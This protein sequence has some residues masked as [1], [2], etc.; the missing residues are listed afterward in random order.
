MRK[1]KMDSEKIWIAV[2]IVVSTLAGTIGFLWRDE[3]K[4]SADERKYLKGE[5][6]DMKDRIRQLEK[7]KDINEQERRQEIVALLRASVEQGERTNKVIE[8]L[9]KAWETRRC[10]A[11]GENPVQFPEDDKDTIRSDKLSGIRKK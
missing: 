9:A 4:R 3:R 11:I 1:R 8:L 6:D 2:C 10:L 5:I 7:E